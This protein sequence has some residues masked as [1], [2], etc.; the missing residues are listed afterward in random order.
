MSTAKDPDPSARN[1]SPNARNNPADSG[2]CAVDPEEWGTQ[3]ASE[4]AAENPRDQ[5]DRLGHTSVM[6]A[7]VELTKPEISFLVALSAAAGFILGSG[8]ALDLW[9]LLHT[10]TGTTLT[11]AGSGTLNHVIEHPLD[12]Q[13]KRTS[14]RPLPNGRISPGLALTLG[15]LMSAGGTVYLF[16]YTNGLVA[17]LAAATVGL[18]LLI[19]TPLKQT[20][21]YNTLIGCFPGALPSLGGWV[22]AAGSIEPRAW[23]LFGVLFAWQMPHF[24]SLAWMYRRDYSR[25]GFVMLPVVEPDGTSTARQTLAFTA[26]TLAFSLLPF[27]TNL[28]DWFYLIG[29]T[30]LGIYFLMPAIRFYHHQTNQNARRILKASVFYIPALLALIV[31]DRLL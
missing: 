3:T 15:L 8:G 1:T 26:L 10:I 11:A 7:V 13:M 16:V 5:V 4:P 17:G 22:A 19:Y 9:L 23:I 27:F 28:A 20:S 24:L 12:D 6:W 25:A 21:R 29:T 2:L 30:G 14:S 31:G 18:Y